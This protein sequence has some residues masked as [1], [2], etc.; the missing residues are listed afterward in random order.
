MIIETNHVIFN[1]LPAHCEMYYYYYH[2][3]IIYYLFT[4]CDLTNSKHNVRCLNQ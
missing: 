2:K 1:K 3:I 4:K